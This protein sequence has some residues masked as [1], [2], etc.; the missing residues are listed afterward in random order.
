MGDPKIAQ[1]KSEGKFVVPYKVDNTTA[2]ILEEIGKTRVQLTNR[3]ITVNISPEVF[4]Y[5]WKRVREGT[6]SS[7]LGIHYS[8]CKAAVYSVNLSSFLV[9][10]INLVLHTGCSPERWSYG[11]VVMIGKIDRIASVNKL[12]TILLMEADFNYQ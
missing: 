7:Y 6:A 12:R 1:Q 5:L 3:N 10:K 9:E 11:I 4:L 2:L 8:H